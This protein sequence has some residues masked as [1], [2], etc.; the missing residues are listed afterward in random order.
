MTNS[1]FFRSFYWGYVYLFPVARLGLYCSCSSVISALGILNKSVFL[2]CLFKFRCNVTSKHIPNY[3]H[4]MSYICIYLTVHKG[5][6]YSIT[7]IFIHNSKKAFKNHS[8]FY[9]CQYFYLTFELCSK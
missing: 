2:L 7:C 1:F 5:K 6:I 3:I 4:I 8:C 9:M